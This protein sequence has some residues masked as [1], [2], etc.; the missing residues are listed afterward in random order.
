LALDLNG[1][2]TAVE[3]VAELAML[4]ELVKP[5]VIARL[6]QALTSTIKADARESLVMSGSAWWKHALTARSTAKSFP[7]D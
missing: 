4:A 1:L 6:V 5:A 7:G 3:L 2:E